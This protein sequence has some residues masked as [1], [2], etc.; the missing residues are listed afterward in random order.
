M[1]EPDFTPFPEIRTTRLLLRRIVKEDVPM[2]LAMRS[3]EKLMKYI[4]KER[5]STL[6]DAEKFFTMIDQSLEKNDGITWCISLLEEPAKMIGSI[7]FWRIIKQHYR[8]EIGYMLH[9]DHWGKGI[10]N[11]A[12]AVVIEYG[13]GA[14]KLHS[15]EA[16]INPANAASAGIL[17]KN[18]FVREAYFKEDFFFRGKFLDTAIYSRLK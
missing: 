12:M 16:H 11:E 18:N 8:A 13:F 2:I 15:I 10:M 1:L 7:G 4:D 5:A 9:H 3:D 14:L 6:E 17:E